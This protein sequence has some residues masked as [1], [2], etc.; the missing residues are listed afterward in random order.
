MRTRSRATSAKQDEGPRK[1]ATTTAATTTIATTKAKGGN[2]SAREGSSSGAEAVNPSPLSYRRWNWAYVGVLLLWPGY[3]LMQ[4]RA[5]AFRWEKGASSNARHYLLEQALLAVGSFVGV[6][7]MVRVMGDYC[8]RKGQTGRD[9]CKRG[10]AAG[11]VDIPESQ[12]LAPGII[13]MVVIIACQLLYS[14]TL[15]SL[16]NYNSSLLSIC[17]MLFLGFVDDVLVRFVRWSFF[18]G[19]SSIVFCTHTHTHTPNAGLTV[20]VQA[21]SA[22]HRHHASALLLQ[23]Q[24]ERHHSQAFA[25]LALAGVPPQVRWMRGHDAPP[26][27]II[28]LQMGAHDRV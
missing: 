19:R 27:I 5:D 18:L 2:S 10:T 12:G 4:L 6:C 3:L 24:H 20:A 7:H 22:A 16:A 21:H 15:E 8:R 11:E 17:F 25:W 23:W 28:L 9:L 26:P 1:A 14:Q 13:Y